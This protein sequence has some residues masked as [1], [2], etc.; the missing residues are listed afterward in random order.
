MILQIIDCMAC[1]FY[2]AHAVLIACFIASRTCFH[3]PSRAGRY[4]TGIF[5]KKIKG[6]ADKVSPSFFVEIGHG[7][8]IGCK[9]AHLLS[10][11]GIYLHTILYR[12][13]SIDFWG[14]IFQ[15]G[16]R[17]LTE[18]VYKIFPSSVYSVTDKIR[19]FFSAQLIS[20]NSNE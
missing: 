12:V 17:P 19:S 11:F 10:P 15:G 8:R 2:R 20:N 13:S 4:S 18:L 16:K 9:W 3:P 6:L 7:V 14:T 1:S 5:Y